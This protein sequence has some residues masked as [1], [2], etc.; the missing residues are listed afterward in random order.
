V[1]QDY[2]PTT[3]LVVVDL[4]NDFTLPTGSLYVPGGEEVVELVNAEVD[5]AAAAGA[6]VV[7]TQ[8]W[9][10]EH[11][12]HFER[13]GGLWPVHCVAGTP[14]AE[15]VEG[16]RLVPGPHG[17][18]E[19]IRKGT[20]TEDGYSA[21]SEVDLASGTTASTRLGVLLDAA[22][23]RSLVVVGLAGDYCVKATAVDGARLGLD[24]VVPLAATR[25]VALSTDDDVV[26]RQEMTA[27]G[28]R[29]V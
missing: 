22:G 25:Y 12:P 2:S 16:L 11:T 10:P 26:A 4:Q 6:R 23:V 17:E 27:A 28:V 9:H 20:G 5:A 29:L 24:V 19:R 15:L 21:F 8:D 18:V 3:A 7:Y 1:P 14:G 13:D